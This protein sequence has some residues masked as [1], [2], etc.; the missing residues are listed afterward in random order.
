MKLQLLIHLWKKNEHWIALSVIVLVHTGLALPPA[1][2]TLCNA[3]SYIVVFFLVIGHWKRILYICTRDVTFLFLVGYA[4]ASLS[5]SVVPDAT[6]DN[7]RA[8]MRTIAFGAYLATCYTFQDLMKLLT[9]VLIV[10]WFLSLIAIFAFKLPFAIFMFK[11]YLGCMMA[12]GATIALLTAL[13]SRKNRW[14]SVI[15][16]CCAVFLIVSSR[17]STSLVAFVDSLLVVP[18]YIILKQHYKLRAFLFFITLLFSTSVAI[19]VTNNLE[20]I[21]VD[22][23]GKDI[24][25]TGRKPLWDALIN[26]G[27]ERPWLGYGYR[28]FW[29]SDYSINALINNPNGWPEVPVLGTYLSTFHSH[30][31]Y[32]ELFLYLGFIGLSLF[33][34]NCLMVLVRV[35]T[36]I[37][38]RPTIENFWMIQILIMMLV[39]NAT[40]SIQILST[41]EILWLLYVSI[42]F[43]SAIQL[44]RIHRSRSLSNK[45]FSLG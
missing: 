34:L 33:M 21:I 25:F 39:V 28:A 16:F 29:S 32:I 9:P 3:L 5:W 2:S 23:L 27:L 42:A 37:S 36:L 35:I 30:N 8:M 10:Y 45:N 40:E 15:C 44:E 26:Q 24:T 11:S 41:G 6:I 13:D 22:W 1:V 4:L 43:S 31:G 18:F 14:L 38:L 20:T 19:F 7:L 12:L 17:S